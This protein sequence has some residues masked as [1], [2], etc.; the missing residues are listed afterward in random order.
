LV[1]AEGK[2]QKVELKKSS[3][4]SRLDEAAIETVKKWRF[5]AAQDGGKVVTSWVQIPIN[6]I[7]E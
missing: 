2:T 3:G 6:F 1:N 7:L 5:I 4:F